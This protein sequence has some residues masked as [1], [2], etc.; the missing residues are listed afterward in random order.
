MTAGIVLGLSAGFSPGPLTT[1]VISQALQYGAREGLKTALSP[2]VTD[3]PIIAVSLFALTRV[4]DSQV[5]LGLISIAGGGFLAYLAYVSFKTNKVDMDV[6]QSAP[7]SLVKGTVAN[8][9][10]PGPY[11]F[12][13]TIG[14]PSVVAAWTQGPWIAAGF[15]AAFYTCLVGGKMSLALAAATSRQLLTGKAYGYVMRFLGVLLLVFAFL[16]FRDGFGFL[17]D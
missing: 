16:L 2:F 14:A 12:W 13:L 4:N 5:V 15:I 9:C 10:N 11:V 3:L 1:L 6:G 8:F 7:Q 17:S